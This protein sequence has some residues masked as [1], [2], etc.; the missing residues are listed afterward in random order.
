MPETQFSALL[1]KPGYAASCNTLSSV[2]GRWDLPPLW[3][4]AALT[5]R[6]PSKKTRREIYKWIARRFAATCSA[7]GGVS[8]KHHDSARRCRGKRWTP[9]Q[10][11]TVWLD[12]DQKILPFFLPLTEPM[13]S[14]SGD[15]GHIYVFM[16]H[17]D[18]R[19]IS[20]LTKPRG[21]KNQG[22]VSWSEWGGGWFVARSLIW[23]PCSMKLI[24]DAT[25]DWAASLF[26]C[27][28]NGFVTVHV[29]F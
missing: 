25:A 17:S 23:W 28:F 7:S 4:C 20:A 16:R 15:L 9:T 26:R 5:K 8:L 29:C 12:L 27:F 11:S 18:M 22:D 10:A 1:L 14:T 3:Q 19:N 6:E 24:K 21:A 13:R 2:Q